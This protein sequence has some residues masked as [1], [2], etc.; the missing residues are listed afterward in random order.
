M[1]FDPQSTDSMFTKILER[2]EHQDKDAAKRHDES[3]KLFARITD[4][5][6]QHDKRITSL[7]TSRAVSIG[8]AGSA[9]GLTGWISHLFSK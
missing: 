9:G 7:E 2:L 5:L 4:Q 3:Q 6:G 1:S 8:I